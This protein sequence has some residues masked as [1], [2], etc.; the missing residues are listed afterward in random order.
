[1]VNRTISLKPE[2]DAQLKETI[3]ASKLINGMLTDYFFGGG[4]LKAEELKSG[5]KEL[6]EDMDKNVKKILAMKEK[7]A[8]MDSKR[9]EV[10]K[11]FKKVDESIIETFRQFPLMSLEA[12]RSRTNATGQKWEDIKAAYKE[13][14]NK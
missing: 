7:L 11:K 13:Y 6:Q 4:D 1:M 3:N 5:I 8:N 2:I 10:K 12:L 9:E 14:F